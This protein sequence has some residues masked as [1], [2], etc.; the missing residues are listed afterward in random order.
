MNRE[1]EGEKQRER[2]RETER[3]RAHFIK[4]SARNEQRLGWSDR[5]EWRR[6]SGGNKDPELF[7]SGRKSL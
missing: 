2:E 3:E 1:K 6:T 5:G 7:S 4:S